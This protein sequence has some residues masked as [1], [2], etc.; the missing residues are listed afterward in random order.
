MA[1][2]VR[3]K[4]RSR[5]QAEVRR[6]WQ[7][8][9]DAKRPTY[10]GPW[11]RRDRRREAFQT[12]KHRWTIV[13]RYRRL[14]GQGDAEAEAAQQAGPAAGYSAS[15]VRKFHRASRKDGKK[16]LLSDV[17]HGRETPPRTPWTV[18]QSLLVFR[19]LLHW[20]GIGWPP[21]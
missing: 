5:R 12:M 9:Q 21:R 1:S 11:K 6:R 8:L 17:A 3:K 14:R 4:K 10:R 19:R 16:G 18:I 15:S 20:V 13:Q 7:D 2:T